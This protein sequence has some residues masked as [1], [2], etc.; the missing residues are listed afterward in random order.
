MFYLQY[1]IKF[2]LR[3]KNWLIKKD[4]ETYKKIVIV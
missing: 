4:Y 1:L 3:F 2:F